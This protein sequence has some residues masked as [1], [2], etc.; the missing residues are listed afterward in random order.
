MVAGEL[1]EMGDVAGGNSDRC[2]N[3]PCSLCQH[4]DLLR[5]ASSVSLMGDPPSRLIGN[6]P[7]WENKVD[8][9]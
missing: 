5:D 8:G 4:L 7:L 3:M 2:C 1:G 6:G 9:S